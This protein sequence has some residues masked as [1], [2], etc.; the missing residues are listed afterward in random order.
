MW[1]DQLLAQELMKERTQLQD[2]YTIYETLE[3]DIKDTISLIELAELENDNNFIAEG[4]KNLE[5]LYT[6]VKKNRVRNIII[7]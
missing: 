6:I 4:K 7:R 3:L 5:N 2:R 1:K